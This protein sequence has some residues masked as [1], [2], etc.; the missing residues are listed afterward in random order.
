MIAAKE[1]VAQLKS[2]STASGDTSTIQ[3]QISAN[4]AA[5]HQLMDQRDAMLARANMQIAGQARAP[6]IEEQAT[7]L[8]N[9]VNTLRN[10]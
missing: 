7:Q 2:M 5:I 8:E 1:R 10:C 4:N 3:E 6:A 9:Q